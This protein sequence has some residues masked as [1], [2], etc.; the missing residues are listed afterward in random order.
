MPLQAH[1]HP[2]T[3]LVPPLFLGVSS[4]YPLYS[5]LPLK[6]ASH[7]PSYLFLSINLQNNFQYYIHQQRLHVFDRLHKAR[8]EYMLVAI[9]EQSY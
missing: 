5:L 3:L 8:V 4:A 6:Y 7:L 1:T 2:L 9:K